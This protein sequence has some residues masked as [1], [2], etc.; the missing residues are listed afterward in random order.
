M[1]CFIKKIKKD[2]NDNKLLWIEILFDQNYWFLEGFS[3]KLF[4]LN[5]DETLEFSCGLIP[6]VSGF[7]QIPL[8]KI[9]GVDQD[10]YDLSFASNRIQILPNNLPFIGICSFFD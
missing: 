7:L 2:E 1:K 6:L 5:F 8:I 3:K 4:S 10:L 9:I